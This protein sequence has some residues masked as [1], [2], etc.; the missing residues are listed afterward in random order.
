[1]RIVSLLFRSQGTV[2]TLGDIS[3]Q[4]PCWPFILHRYNHSTFDAATLIPV[5][6]TETRYK[7]SPSLLLAR[8]P[9]I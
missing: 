6:F 3:T 7:M 1:M 4:F 2:I 8:L 5:P 9:A